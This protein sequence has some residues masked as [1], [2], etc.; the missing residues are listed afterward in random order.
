MAVQ[1]PERANCFE[2]LTKNKVSYL[3]S[4]DTPLEMRDWA[5]AIAH[6]RTLTRQGEKIKRAL[7]FRFP[8]NITFSPTS[9]ISRSIDEEFILRPLMFHLHVTSM[10]FLLSLFFSFFFLKKKIKFN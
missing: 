4:A 2:I 5:K 9:S 3:I 1:N 7:S 6:A 8:R 10:I